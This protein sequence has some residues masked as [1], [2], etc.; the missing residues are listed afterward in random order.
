M[1]AAL[2]ATLLAI[3]QRASSRT[4]LLSSPTALN[5]RA[6]LFT[7]ASLF[8]VHC[9]AKSELI[10]P[11]IAD[12]ASAAADTATPE[13]CQWRLGPFSPI[14]ADVANTTRPFVGH[15]SEGAVASDRVLWLWRQFSP[16]PDGSVRLSWSAAQIDFDA[17]QMG[18][19]RLIAEERVP[20][21]GLSIIAEPEIIATRDGFATITWQ[22]ALGCRA[23][24]LA[25]DG[26]ERSRT[27]LFGAGQFCEDLAE[28]SDGSLRAWVGA[29]PIG[30]S[31]L[32]FLHVTSFV[33]IDRADNVNVRERPGGI[34]IARATFADRTGVELTVSRDENSLAAART[35]ADGRRT[36]EEI[37]L[38]PWPRDREVSFARTHI[39]ARGAVASW[40]I[41]EAAGFRTAEI[42]ELST[43][44]AITLRRSLPL[45]TSAA[46]PLISLSIDTTD[47]HIFLSWSE[48]TT[49]GRAVFVRVFDRAGTAL[50]APLPVLSGAENTQSFIRATP[51]GALVYGAA[52]RINEAAAFAAPLRCE[53]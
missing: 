33:E 48:V 2:R 1:T 5:T 7:F 19:T 45:G 50:T 6:T 11:R 15:L 39:T 16:T 25:L 14:G 12:D 40:A 31:R 43:R 29:R 13:L 27:A 4:S 17:Q 26:S 49:G 30:T 47:T 37:I 42:A 8:T 36:G 38:Q 3:Q 9:G 18:P 28:L 32:P 51:R 22:G 10:A 46:T 44:G 53:R 52:Q 41:S 34:T 24:R 23:H 20:Q 35:G 21:G